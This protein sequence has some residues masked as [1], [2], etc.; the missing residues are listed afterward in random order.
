M[1]RKDGPA[2]YPMEHPLFA[3][4]WHAVVAYSDSPW[5][6]EGQITRDVMNHLASKHGRKGALDSRAPITLYGKA[7]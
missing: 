5:L 6:S 3:Y 7:A 1:Y 4:W 2:E